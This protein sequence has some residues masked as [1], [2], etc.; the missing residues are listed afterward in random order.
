MEKAGNKHFEKFETS[1]EKLKDLFD[2]VN[3]PELKTMKPANKEQA[4]EEFLQND[5]L[6]RPNFEYTYDQD[7]FDKKFE[8]FRKAGEILSNPENELSNKERFVENKRFLFK[9]KRMEFLESIFMVQNYDGAEKQKYA[10][11]FRELNNEIWGEADFATYQDLM[12]EKIAK[13][14]PEKLDEKGLQI[15]NEFTQSLKNE[16]STPAEKRFKPRDETLQFMQNATREFYGDLL[17]MVPEAPE[18]GYSEIEVFDTFT[19]IVEELK[20]RGF[21]QKWMVEWDNKNG[22]ISVNSIE[23]KVKIPVNSNKKRKTREA[24]QGTIAHEIGVHLY[25]SETGSFLPEYQY[26]I[27]AEGYLDSE[28]GIARVMEMSLNGK[29]VEAGIPYYLTVGLAEFEGKNF[30]ET[31]ET[32]WRMILLSN[33]KNDFSKEAIEKAKTLAYNR[34]FRIFRADDNLAWHKDLSY[35][36]GATK[37]WQYIES[38]LELPTLFDELLLGGKNDLFNP[39]QQQQIYE[40]KVSG[41]NRVF[42]ENWNEIK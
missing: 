5:E 34:C 27:G 4:K 32:S 40:M 1:Q 33:G 12:S 3:I 13:I 16:Y 23:K 36:N 17:E 7:F 2:V 38:N 42:D 15:Y 25:R 22:T 21:S 26:E 9:A 20:N 8:A 30:R 37:I 14:E 31:F 29:Y 28:E 11:R 6:A 18:G 41:E 39:E 10:E 19:E 35:Y 24:L